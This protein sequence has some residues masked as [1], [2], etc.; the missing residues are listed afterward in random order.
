MKKVEKS[1]EKIN[2]EEY[3]VK[4]EFDLEEAFVMWNHKS[5]SGTNYLTGTCGDMKII[6]FNN[7]DKKNE[8][9]PDIRIYTI[10]NDQ[11]SKEAVASLWRN[12]SKSGKYYLTGTDNENIKLVGFYNDNIIEFPD[13]PF[14][15]V[16]YKESENK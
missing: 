5:K 6:G 9:E 15:R 12:V 8:K 13:R 11:I 16:Y 10:E 7:T 1:N 4:K 2:K 14:I 3:E